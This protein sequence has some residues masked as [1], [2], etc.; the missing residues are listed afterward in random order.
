[1]NLTSDQSDSSGDRRYHR[2][3]HGQSNWSARLPDAS[4]PAGRH[5]WRTDTE[6]RNEWVACSK[7]K[8]QGK[9]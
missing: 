7:G 9:N 4:Q 5:G 6:G 2:S 8:S 3:R 1:M